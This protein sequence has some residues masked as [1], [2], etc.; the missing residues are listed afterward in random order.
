MGGVILSLLSLSFPLHLKSLLSLYPSQAGDGE[1]AK[2]AF[3]MKHF[4][5]LSGVLAR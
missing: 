1:G 5:F 4:A 3:C 2:S